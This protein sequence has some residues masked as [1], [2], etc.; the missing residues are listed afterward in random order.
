MILC[1]KFTDHCSAADRSTL[2]SRDSKQDTVSSGSKTSNTTWNTA[3]SQQLIISS[4][5]L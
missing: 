2:C 1:V 4:T 3:N 5:A